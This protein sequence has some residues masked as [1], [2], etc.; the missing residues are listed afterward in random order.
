MPGST[1]RIFLLG[2]IAVPDLQT[3]KLTKLLIQLCYECCVD[4]QLKQLQ[5]AI[6]KSVILFKIVMDSI[7]YFS[8]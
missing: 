5:L 8:K 2:I 1:C 6:C 4:V 7:G 3:Y